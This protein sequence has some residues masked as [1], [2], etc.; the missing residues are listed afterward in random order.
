M[1]RR[2]K[3]D[4]MPWLP[5]KSYRTI[6]VHMSGEQRRVYDDLEEELEA[7]LDTG[8]S[9]Q[10][11]NGLALAMRLRQWSLEPKLL[12]PAT[13]TPSAVTTTLLDILDDIIQGGQQ[14]V[15]FSWF[16]SY[17][18]FLS[19]LLTKQKIPHGMIA[20]S[21]EGDIVEE[22]RV[23]LAFQQGKTPVMLASITKMIGID[24]DSASIGIFTDRYY[25]PGV[26]K[27]AEERLERGVKTNKVTIIDIAPVDSVYQDI[28]YTLGNKTEAFNET[29]ALRRVAEAFM[30][31]RK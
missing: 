12:E 24:L 15:I 11:K 7:Y 30:K 23:R 2:E 17:L 27:Q 13:K 4:I 21:A 29:V 1:V 8:Q 31:R 28:Q 3:K 22:R 5:P 14:V 16:A 19:D 18:R 10:A 26:N 9:I 20:G 25:V 6:P